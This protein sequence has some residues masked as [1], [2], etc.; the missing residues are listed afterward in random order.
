VDG[1]Q[2]AGLG[3]RGIDGTVSA[4]APAPALPDDLFDVAGGFLEP[5]AITRL[6]VVAMMMVLAPVL[7]VFAKYK[8]AEK[9]NQRHRRNGAKHDQNVL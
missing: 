4:P 6:M 7:F 9:D 2:A 3:E 8:H 5:F 1:R